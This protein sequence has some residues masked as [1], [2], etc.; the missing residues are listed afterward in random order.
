MNFLSWAVLGSQGCRGKKIQTA[1]SIQLMRPVLLCFHGQKKYSF[2]KKKYPSIRTEKLHD[3]KLKNCQFLH[4]KK[5]NIG[6]TCA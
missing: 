1:I 3:L 2:L 6:A 4:K 5:L